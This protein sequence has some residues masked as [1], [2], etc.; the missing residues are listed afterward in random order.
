MPDQQQ[1]QTP[2]SAKTRGQ[3]SIGEDGVQVEDHRR[4]AKP[5]WAAGKTGGGR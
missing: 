3:W 2:N 4:T 5:A 1:R